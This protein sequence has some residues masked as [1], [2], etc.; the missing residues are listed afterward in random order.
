MIILANHG[1]VSYGENVE[2]CLKFILN[3]CQESGLIVSD[4]SS[5]PMYGHGFATLFLGEVFGMT[6]DEQVKQKAT[7]GIN[8]LTWMQSDA[9]LFRTFFQLVNEPRPGFEDQRLMGGSEPLQVSIGLAVALLVFFAGL[10]GVPTDVALRE[11]RAWLAR[12]RVPEFAGRKT[13]K[14]VDGV[15]YTG[16]FT[17]DFTLAELRTLRAKERIPG[18]RPASTA[19]DSVSREP[20]VASSGATSTGQAA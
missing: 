20:L 4:T 8:A 19:F 6:G 9:G 16:W 7:S 17:E 15:T 18:T 1:T 12:F 5:G 14:V 3:S 11:G 10:Q 13:T 2:R